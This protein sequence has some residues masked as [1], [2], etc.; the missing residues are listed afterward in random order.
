MKIRY[1]SDYHEMSHLASESILADI[2]LETRAW[3][4]VATGNSPKKVYDNLGKLYNRNLGRFKN[5]GIVKLDEWGG[6]PMD[7]SNSCE[8]FIQNRILLPLK[9]PDKQYIAFASN[10][11]DPQKECDRIQN[12]IDS[13]GALDVCIL[14]LGK[15]GHIGFN[16]P[17]AFLQSKCHIAALSKVSMQHH[18]VDSLSDK[19]TYGLTLGMGDI[20]KSKKI[21]LLITGVGKDEIVKELLTSKI[22]TYLPASF[23]WLH[24]NAEC[25]IDSNSMP[26]LKP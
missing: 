5:L 7:A 22:S 4:G 20:I 3:L 15:N 13:I 9:I 17:A 6:I 26:E 14:G 21:I 24:A 16:E 23:L 11:L 2:K 12:E 19:P 18:M 1:C 8:T 10:P 25:Y